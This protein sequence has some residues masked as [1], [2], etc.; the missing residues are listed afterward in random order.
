MKEY[1]KK[2]REMRKDPKKRS[3]YLLIVYGIFFA[4]VFIYIKFNQYQTTPNIEEN[5]DNEKT[6]IVDDN[7]DNVT[8]YEYKVTL[9]IENDVINIDGLFY[10]SNQIFTINDTKYYQNNSNIYLYDDKSIVDKIE[11]PLNKFLYSNINT[12][13]QNYQYESKTE[14]KDNNIKYIYNLSNEEIAKIFDDEYINE[15]NVEITIYQNNDY[16]Y[17]VEYDLT[18]YYNKSY[19]IIIEYSHV[20][21]ITNL[22][23]NM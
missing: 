18:Q 4:F 12:I 13:I 9:N 3:I 10:N 15:G 16:I 7:N 19:K 1:W 21:E 23:M 11:Y 20:N 14:Y 22:E 8:G 2:F 6:T 5:I 17:K